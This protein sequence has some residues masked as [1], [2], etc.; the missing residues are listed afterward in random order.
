MLQ[1]NLELFPEK[2]TSDN[3]QKSRMMPPTALEYCRLGRIAPP[4]QN[5]VQIIA[6]F[7]STTPGIQPS[8]AVVLTN[9]CC[10]CA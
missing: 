6:G 10:F 5:F 8:D 7:W 3:V 9:E 4:D 2:S 1:E